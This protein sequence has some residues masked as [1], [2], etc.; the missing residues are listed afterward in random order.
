M[1]PES[2]RFLAWFDQEDDYDWDEIVINA[3]SVRA[4]V[5]VVLGFSSKPS[6]LAFSKI[7]SKS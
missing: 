2:S 7:L 5:S 3:F 6:A 1:I 4:W